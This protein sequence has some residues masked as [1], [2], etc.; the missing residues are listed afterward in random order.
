MCKPVLFQV[1]GL[2]IQT[3]REQRAKQVPFHRGVRHRRLPARLGPSCRAVHWELRGANSSLVSCA[4]ATWASRGSRGPGETLKGP[5]RGPGTQAPAAGSH[6]LWPPRIPG[7]HQPPMEPCRDRRRFPKVGN[8]GHPYPLGYM[9]LW[10]A[11]PR[12][13]GGDH[14]LPLPL[15]TSL[16]EKSR[17][18]GLGK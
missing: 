3:V 16:T 8:Q 17:Q 6:G 12:P 4:A 5:H 2:A 18:A 14:R 1:R 15:F 10:W 11:A 13:L 9:C 7:P